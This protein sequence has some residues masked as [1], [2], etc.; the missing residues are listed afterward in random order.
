MDELPEMLVVLSYC[1]FSFLTEPGFYVV[2]IEGRNEETGEV[3]FRSFKDCFEDMEA[4]YAEAVANGRLY[5]GIWEVF[6]H[7]GWNVTCE[8]ERAY[9]G[10]DPAGP[11]PDVQ[12]DLNA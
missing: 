3:S 12:D 4:A 11:G 7:T 9:W 6:A 10:E 1:E 8:A 5:G 2:R